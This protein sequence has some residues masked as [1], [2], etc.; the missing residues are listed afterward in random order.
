MIFK[1]VFND[2]GVMSNSFGIFQESLLSNLLILDLIILL[3]RA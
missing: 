2:F 1:C 3:I